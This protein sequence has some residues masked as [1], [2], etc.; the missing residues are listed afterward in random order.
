[1]LAGM[2]FSREPF[3]KG[4]DNQD[5]LV[6]IAKFIGTDDILNYC[7][8]YKIKLDPYFDDKLVK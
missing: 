8:K 1:M 5:Q 3:F 7:S 4:A 6:K 2:M